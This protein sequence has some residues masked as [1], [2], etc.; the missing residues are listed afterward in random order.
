MLPIFLFRMQQL[1]FLSSRNKVQCFT[2]NNTYL[3]LVTPKFPPLL[4]SSMHLIVSI[5][6]F[7]IINN[8]ISLAS[9][10]QNRSSVMPL[11]RSKAYKGREE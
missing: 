5:L 3:G 1:I 11:Q 8:S 7:S 4:Y 9:K 6:M 2:S 10:L